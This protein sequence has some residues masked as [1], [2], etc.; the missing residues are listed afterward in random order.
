MFCPAR[1]IAFAV[2]FLPISIFC[3]AHVI[4]LIFLLS[5]FK[6]CAAHLTLPRIS[7]DFILIISPAAIVSPTTLFST[8]TSLPAE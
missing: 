8:L 2:V 5:I 4:F 1:Y 6:V 3:P 7:L